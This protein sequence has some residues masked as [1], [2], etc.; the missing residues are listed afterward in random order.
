M[1][2]IKDYHSLFL[3][4][5]NLKIKD[6][7]II[8]GFN[9]AGKTTLAKILA[10]LTQNQA[11]FIDNKNI[12][13]ISDNIRREKINYIPTTIDIFD[14]FITVKEF[15]KLNFINKN[16]D[17]KLLNKIIEFLNIK[18][19]ENSN[20]KYLSSGESKLVLIAG[21]V[22]HNAKY[23]IFD[24]PTIN[25]D[26]YREKILFNL[27]KENIFLQK[28]IIITHNLNFAY[29]LGYDIVFIKNGKI[30]FNGSNKEFFTN[31][32]LNHFYQGSL[33][34]E[35]NNILTNLC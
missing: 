2:K 34:M 14:S 8:L 18:K 27:F 10:Y 35:N 32:N 24:E 5:I 9:G 20:C 21:A 33:K 1:L 13:D 31:K 12:K 19:I 25:L 7:I 28:K 26:P 6:N 16:I 3:N 15:L 17:I 29:K 22:I 23:T 11:V 30:A 4:N